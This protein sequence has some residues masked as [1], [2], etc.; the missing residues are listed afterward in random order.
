MCKLPRL[1]VLNDTIY[2][3]IS[4]L[5]R[6]SEVRLLSHYIRHTAIEILKAPASRLPYAAPRSNEV[7]AFSAVS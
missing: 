6:V 3:N 1:L 7:E 4:L 5:F 2:I